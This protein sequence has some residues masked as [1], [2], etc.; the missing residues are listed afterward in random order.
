VVL[1]HT[2]STWTP[3][4]RVLP[5]AALGALVLLAGAVAI[6]D[7]ETPPPLDL[8]SLETALDAAQTRR[9]E[10]DR[11]EPTESREEAERP[12]AQDESAAREAREEARLKHRIDEQ[13]RAQQELMRRTKD[14]ASPAESEVPAATSADL[15]TQANSRM[16]PPAPVDREYPPAIFDSEKVTIPAG[17]WGNRRK[18]ELI[19]LVLDADGD[20]KPE[21]VRY[22]APESR[23]RVR[24][25]EDRNYDGVT[26][27]WSDYEWGAVV[28]RVLDSNDDGN[29]DVWERYEHGFLTS[30]EVDRDDDGVRDAFHVYKGRSLVLEKH[31]A[32]ND[33][34]IDRIIYFED[35][36]RVRSEDDLDTDGRMDAWTTFTVVDGVELVSR[37]DRDSKGRGSADTFEFFEAREGRAVIHRRDQDIDGD[38]QIDIISYFRNGKLI[39]RQISDSNL[40]G[41][42]G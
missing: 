26:D 27:A 12:A 28:A 10:P 34:R 20:G 7:E 41:K 13:L 15:E 32:N 17:Q 37:I 29:P 1:S 24:Q 5:W 16:A 38:G 39:R 3:W 6:A 30:K 21:L 23:L 33:G 11:T 4:V 22:L 36:R 9:A 40:L 2:R 42:A 25:E 19:A 14:D 18:L 35:R 8:Q 31:D